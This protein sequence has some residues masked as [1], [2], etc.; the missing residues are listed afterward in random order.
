MEKVKLVK[1][2]ESQGVSLPSD[3]H[4]EGEEVYVCRI[5]QVVCLIPQDDP[6]AL[7]A[8]SVNMFTDDCFREDIEELPLQ[9]REPME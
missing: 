5:G 1:N 3:C 2:K 8:M 9:E 6:W 4:F 7:T